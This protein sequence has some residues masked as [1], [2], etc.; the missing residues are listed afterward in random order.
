MYPKVTE[1][2][3]QERMVHSHAH[4]LFRMSIM[5]LTRLDI[6][7]CL[8]HKNDNHW[9]EGVR[10]EILPVKKKKKNLQEI[11]EHNGMK[12]TQILFCTILLFI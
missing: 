6:K 11:E 2:Q 9:H 10:K 4:K 5:H 3:R 12:Y 7:T 1:A 8:W